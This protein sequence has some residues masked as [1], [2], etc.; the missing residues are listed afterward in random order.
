MEKTL[1]ELLDAEADELC[2][3]LKYA[4]SGDRT[5][6]RAGHYT[7]K[8]HT[9]AGK[10][11]LKVPKLRTATFET[12][13]IERFRRR[14]MNIEESLIEMYLAGVSVRQVETITEA[15]RGTRVSAS[16]VSRLDKRIYTHIERW[17]NRPIS[18]V[19]LIIFDA[20]MGW[21]GA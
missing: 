9:G 4:R 5:D 15:L 20:C 1:N 14:E 2:N 13:I 16:T 12:A 6:T 8:L 17:R 18:S 10:V 7:R 11:E 21:W 3:A 19:Q